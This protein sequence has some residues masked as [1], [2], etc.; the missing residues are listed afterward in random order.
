M[1]NRKRGFIY[2]TYN[3]QRVLLKDS[4]SPAV[5]LHRANINLPRRFKARS[6]AI[7]TLLA[8]HTRFAEQIKVSP[9]KTRTLHDTMWK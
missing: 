3:R 7:G 4:G 2:Y 1:Y 5:I 8:A 9:I 6:N